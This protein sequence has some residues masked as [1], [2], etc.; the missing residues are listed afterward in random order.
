[1][2]I[3]LQA[4]N[5]T[6]FKIKRSAESREKLEPFNKDLFKKLRKKFKV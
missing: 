3:K 4:Q 5:G 6:E 2:S 1:M